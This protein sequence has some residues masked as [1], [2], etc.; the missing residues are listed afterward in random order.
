MKHPV[1]K[2]GNFEFHY[3]QVPYDDRYYVVKYYK[4]G[5]GKKEIARFSPA[6]VNLIDE[7]FA[8][9]V[10]RNDDGWNQTRINSV[11]RFFANKEKYDAYLDA[12][13]EAAFQ[14]IKKKEAEECRKKKV[15]KK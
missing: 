13:D 9:A 7:M 11:E 6:V 1:M 15:K 3:I 2:I 10:H 5:H 8:I 4:G 12:Q 14:A